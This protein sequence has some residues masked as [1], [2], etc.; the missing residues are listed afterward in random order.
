M[1]DIHDWE[2][3]VFQE[4]KGKSVSS[5]DARLVCGVV[6]S[7]LYT[8]R[9]DNSAQPVKNI[10]YDSLLGWKVCQQIDSLDAWKEY[11]QQENGNATSRVSWR[12][13]Q[14]L[15][16]NGVPVEKHTWFVFPEK[17]SDIDASLSVSYCWDVFVQACIDRKQTSA[18]EIPKQIAYMLSCKNPCL[19]VDVASWQMMGV[20]SVQEITLLLATLAEFSRICAHTTEWLH[21]VHISVAV[22]GNIFENVAK[23]RAIRRVV[24]S[25]AV[26]AGIS[27]AYT[28]HAT[29]ALRMWT[30]FDGHVN[31]LRATNSAIASIWGGADVITTLPFDCLTG[32]SK[33]SRRIAENIHYV[34]GEESQLGNWVDPMAGSYYMENFT[35]SL[36]EKG[37]NAFTEIEKR[38]GL[39]A[40]IANGNTA[41]MVQR[42]LKQRETLIHTRKIPI[43]GT[44]EY[45]N[46][47]EKVSLTKEQYAALYQIPS[48]H[49]RDSQTI[50]EMRL[51]WQEQGTPTVSIFVRGDMDTWKAR[52]DFVSQFFAIMG[53][54]SVVVDTQTDAGEHIQC[55]C[56]VATDGVYSTEGLEWATE[57]GQRCSLLFLAGK[58][59]HNIP[60]IT[61]L[62]YGMNIVEKWNGIRDVL[63]IS[64]HTN[65]RT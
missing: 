42:S 19:Y 49:R 53:W 54:D 10:P 43:T 26:Q 35:A 52:A 15:Q 55:A 37:W 40:E 13:Y 9:P 28:I 41:Q 39:I 64:N 33:L 4:L 51:L 23:L 57:V 7:I 21:W 24:D 3:K 62:Y 56:I 14:E 27:G 34:L 25:F 11:R 47:A 5:L 46:P 6:N 36:T 16:A 29:N 18:E 30:L 17:F 45:A 60:H 8:Q 58:N 2:A 59:T 48:L 32:S 12:D 65:D 22:D 50:E 38:G 61:E 20:D 63:A 31:L 44:T 1:Y